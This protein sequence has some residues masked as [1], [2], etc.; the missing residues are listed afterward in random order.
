MRSGFT[1]SE[2]KSSSDDGGGGGNK[3]SVFDRIAE[4]DLAG[5]QL[6]ELGCQPC[7]AS[8]SL[9]DLVHP[10]RSLKPSEANLE[11]CSDSSPFPPNQRAPNRRVSRG[12]AANCSH[13]GYGTVS[14]G[15]TEPPSPTRQSSVPRVDHAQQ[16]A[17]HSR[18]QLGMCSYAL[19]RIAA[20][21]QG[22]HPRGPA[23]M[24]KIIRGISRSWP[25]SRVKRNSRTFPI[26]VL[27]GAHSRQTCVNAPPNL[28]S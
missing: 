12:T 5:D 4:Q 24:V 21:R 15:P 22:S 19:T 20:G 11:T 27:I 7:A 1:S 2:D 6:T 17:E 28:E 14:A 13:P 25:D 8:H 23:F 16:S 3:R 9:C 18:T 26:Q 10:R